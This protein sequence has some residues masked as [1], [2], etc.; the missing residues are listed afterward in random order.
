[1]TS[2]TKKAA[3]VVD[4]MLQVGW[5]GVGGWVG[6]GQLGTPFCRWAGRRDCPTLR[7]SLLPCPALQLSNVDVITSYL[8]G[9]KDAKAMPVAKRLEEE[10]AGGWMWAGWA[11]GCVCG[12]L[13]ASGWPSIGRDR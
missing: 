4:S 5:R 1:V 13:W 7:V 2:T 6:G 10:I 8:F 11:S 3:A 9:S 12:H